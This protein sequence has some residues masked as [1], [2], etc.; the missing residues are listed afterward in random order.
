MSSCRSA[1]VPTPT[2]SSAFAR[3]ARRRWPAFI[4]DELTVEAR[5]ANR[6]GRVY[7]DA[8]RNGFAQTVVA[9]YSVRARPH[10]PVSTPLA[11]TEVRPSL[12]PLKFHLGN[13]ERRL[14][15]ADP[16]SGFWKN[17]QTLPTGSP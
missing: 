11:W 14:D 7:L 8:A 16:W 5:I 4:P 6:K 12:D 9:P 15:R 2:P 1:A 17:R 10:A 13:F 3:Q